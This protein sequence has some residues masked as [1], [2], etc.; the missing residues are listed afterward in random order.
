[1]FAADTGRLRVIRILLK[2]GASVSASNKHGHTTLH[3]PVRYRYLAVT[4]VL[5]KAGADPE[6]KT[7]CAVTA[8][9]LIQGHTQ[10][11]LAA[12]EGFCEGIV[13]L[14]DARANI[15]N[16]M[17]NESTP[18]YLSACRGRLNAARVFLGAKANLQSGV[19]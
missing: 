8:P 3:N 4:K 17:T 18:F 5:I 9:V 11:Q 19:K 1:M 7:D 2:F 6:A 14:I 15:E 12:A 10:L 13:A 16:R